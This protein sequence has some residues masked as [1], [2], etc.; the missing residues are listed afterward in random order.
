M[1]QA[2]CIML[3]HTAL[4]GRSCGSWPAP[5]VVLYLLEGELPL[6]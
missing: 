6:A 5:K 1:G 2:H 4:A 3:L